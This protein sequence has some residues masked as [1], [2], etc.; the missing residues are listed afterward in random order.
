M[1][2]LALF[3]AVCLA[4]L[5]SRSPVCANDFGIRLDDGRAHWGL[6]KDANHGQQQE[7]QAADC[8]QSCSHEPVAL[9]RVEVAPIMDRR[10]APASL[11]VETILNASLKTPDRPPKA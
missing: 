9:D 1:K 5:W 2:F 7:K 11:R 10:S 4:V 6:S 8:C 3:V